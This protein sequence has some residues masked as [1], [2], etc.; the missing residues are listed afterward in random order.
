[1]VAGSLRRM[2]LSKW[3][4]IGA[5]WILPQAAWLHYNY[6]FEQLGEHVFLHMWIAALLFLAANCGIAAFFVTHHFSATPSGSKTH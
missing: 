3:A 6:R 4:G 5:A 1:M 2:T